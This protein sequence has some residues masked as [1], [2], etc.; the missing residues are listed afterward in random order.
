M[1]NQLS[2]IA[3]Q[4]GQWVA[5]WR[6]YTKG[7]VAAFIVVWL[8]FVYHAGVVA[9]TLLLAMAVAMV[10]AIVRLLRGEWRRSTYTSPLTVL[11]RAGESFQGHLGQ[12]D[13]CWY[14]PDI[15][16][17]WISP[18]DYAELVD[19]FDV[20]SAID[21]LNRTMHEEFHRRFASTYSGMSPM[22]QISVDHKLQRN[23]FVV[24]ADYHQVEPSPQPR[25]ATLRYAERAA[26]TYTF[27]LC[28]GN[29]PAQHA[30]EHSARVGSSTRCDIVI[31]DPN[32]APEH[33]TVANFDGYW[34]LW[35]QSPSGC[36]VNGQR[37]APREW[38]PLTNGD[39]ITWG[40]ATSRAVSTVS[41]S[42]ASSA[43]ARA[44]GE[45]HAF[46]RTG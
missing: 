35:S 10:I 5:S 45:T 33:A 19:H 44:G 37:T 43:R 23:K 15:I 46:N 12:T 22:A 6:P 4:L 21:E 32:V 36:L 29:S 41:C 3:T 25:A 17:V 27:A 38:I 13:G 8:F 26:P 28:T 20:A 14:G 16:T 7:I 39:L 11:E 40:P 34:W 30:T 2:D 9:G 24:T 18:S 42:D 1:R 31:I